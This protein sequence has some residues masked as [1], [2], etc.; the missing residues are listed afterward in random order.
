MRLALLAAPILL[1]AC[2]A[3]ALD[4][5]V[6]IHDPSTVVQCQGKYYTWGTGGGLPGLRRRLDLASGRQGLSERHG[7]RRHSRR[8][9][10]LHVCRG[11]QSGATEGG[12]QS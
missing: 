12:H 9:P 11:E 5:Q 7:P 4:G 1:L 10:F 6:R 8:R 2:R 3:M